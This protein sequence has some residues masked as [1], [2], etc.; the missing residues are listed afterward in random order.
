[1]SNNSI[2]GTDFRG[3]FSFEPTFTASG[4]SSPTPIMKGGY[5]ISCDQ[6]CYVVVDDT[7]NNTSAPATLPTTQPNTV[8]KARRIRAGTIDSLEVAFDKQSISVRGVSTSG[9]L[10]INGPAETPLFP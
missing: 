4:P 7:G 1:M 8:N 10:S 6:D 9:T 3:A 2:T 5:Q